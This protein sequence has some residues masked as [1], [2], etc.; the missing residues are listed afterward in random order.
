MLHIYQ[1]TY[2]GSL[3]FYSTEDY[4]LLFS[5][6]CVKARKYNI[7][8]IGICFMIDHLHLLVDANSRESISSF[9]SE[10]S[11]LYAKAFN[12]STRKSGK[13]FNPGFG[14]AVKQGDK[15]I[16]TACSYL[17]NNPCEKKICSKAEDYRW[18]FL[19]FAV[20]DHPFS[21]KIILNSV[22]RPMR[23]AL[24]LLAVLRNADRILGYTHLA[25]LFT[26]LNE[27]EREQLTDCIICKY[28]CVDYQR[29][30]A[31]Y[32][33]YEKMCL[34]F[35]SNQGSEYDISE[36]FEPGGH[37]IYSVMLAT[38]QKRFGFK[39]VKDILDLG[40]SEKARLARRLSSATGARE[41]E[42]RKVFRWQTN[43]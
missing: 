2:D 21:E 24:E 31:L 6:I 42:I 32:G 7:S 39:D 29:L 23:R 18:N 4:L 12:S 25:R 34:A 10:Y 30:L 19:A 16:R 3:L 8:L 1:R 37:S 13:L 38:L 22:S 28:N 20:S 40:Q 17:Y 35:A 27:K 33:S 5:S 43:R 26:G 11:R 9:V 41:W 14:C 36:V 15:R